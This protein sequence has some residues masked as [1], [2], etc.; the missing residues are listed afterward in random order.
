LAS[1]VVGQIRA[2]DHAATSATSP[3]KP[4]EPLGGS[5]ASEQSLSRSCQ[6]QDQIHVEL[7]GSLVLLSDGGVSLGDSLVDGSVDSLP[8]T[9][10]DPLLDP[11]C[12]WLAELLAE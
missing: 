7:H 2:M 3:S 4:P 8:E 5:P 11:L 10:T 1:I 9:L 12:E 6:P